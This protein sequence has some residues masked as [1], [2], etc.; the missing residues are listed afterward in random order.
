M[1][2]FNK[3]FISRTNLQ[4]YKILAN[5]IVY[6]KLLSTYSI[7]A[8]DQATGHLGVAVQTHQVSV[9][10]MVPFLQPG[11]GAIATQSLVNISFGPMALAMLREGV[12]AKTVVHAL[13]AS[14][15]G[16]SRRQ[17]AVV[18]A[19]GNVGAYTGDGCI[20]YAGHYIG[21]C[22]SVQANMMTNDTV[23]DAM[24]HAYE[25]S[26]GD[27]AARMMAALH[28]AQNEDGDIRGM[29]SAALHIVSGNSSDPSWESLY[30]LR[31]DESSQPLTELERL[32]RLQRAQLISAEGHDMLDRGDVSGALLKWKQAREIAPDNEEMAY[33][34][35]IA[36]ADKRPIPDSVS[37]ASRIIKQALKDEERYNQW[38]ELIR[39]LAHVGIMEREGADRELLSELGEDSA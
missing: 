14:D 32:V 12:D 7:V 13:I 17:L 19:Y 8:R 6:S 22:Y 5:K 2:G 38:M 27:L 34:Q 37:V 31:V 9:G 16:R 18:D 1:T 20:P 33:W 10:R 29:Q 3:K 21:E 4:G 35:A 36:L 25:S 15:S 23:I 11:V 24:R 26:S 39:R 30:N 28:A